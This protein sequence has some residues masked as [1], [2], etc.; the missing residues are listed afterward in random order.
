VSVRGEQLLRLEREMRGLLWA[1]HNAQESL[2]NLHVKPDAIPKLS[3][4]A[5]HIFDFFSGYA[6]RAQSELARYGLDAATE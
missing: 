1:L 2:R 6:R 5:A 3:S 4:E